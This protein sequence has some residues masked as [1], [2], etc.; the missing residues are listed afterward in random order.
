MRATEAYDRRSTTF[1][2]FRAL[3]AVTT[4]WVPSRVSAVYLPYTYIASSA[5][6]QGESALHLTNRL[7]IG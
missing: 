6:V 4:R 7:S 2:Y 5:W 3:L 1:G